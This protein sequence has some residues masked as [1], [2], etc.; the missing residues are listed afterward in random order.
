[1]IDDKPDPMFKDL[2]IHYQ[3]A[4]RTRAISFGGIG[5]RPERGSV[6]NMMPMVNHLR[7]SLPEQ[8]T[9]QVVR[10]I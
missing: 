7:H 5:G 8:R 4:E 3:I 6:R 10:V 1:M 2:N 9:R